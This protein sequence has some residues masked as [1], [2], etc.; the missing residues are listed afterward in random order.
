[1]PCEEQRPIAQASMESRLIAAIYE[2]RLWRRSALLR[3]LMGISFESEHALIVSALDLHNGDR[4]LDLGCGPGIH[5]RPLARRVSRGWVVGID[6][7]RAMLQRAALLAERER[8]DNLRLVRAHAER[9]PLA[10]SSVKAACCCGALHLFPDA[11][12]ALREVH[13]VL[14]P[15]GR[16]ALAAFR[17]R[18]TRFSERFAALRRARTGIDAYTPERLG[19]I[20]QSA[21]FTRAECHHARGVWLVM[22][23]TR[24][25]PSACQS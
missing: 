17:S 2:G 20:L 13:R 8:V 9:L 14:A 24:A 6:L 16:L 15:G 22:S 10:S 5:S 25:Q 19:A 3:L 12:A 18:G 4:V 1:M 7:S 11:T 21:G 23:A